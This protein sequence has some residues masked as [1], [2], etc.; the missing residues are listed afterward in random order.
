LGLDFHFHSKDFDDPD[1]GVSKNVLGLNLAIEVSLAGNLKKNFFIKCKDVFF[2]N[3]KRERSQLL[4]KRKKTVPLP[5]LFA[6]Q[7]KRDHVR[8]YD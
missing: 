2:L 7:K 8:L 5:C 4:K 1:R 6:S 3:K